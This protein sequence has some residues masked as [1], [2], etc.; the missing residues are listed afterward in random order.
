MGDKGKKAAAATAGFLVGGPV[1][2]AVAYKSTESYQE[3][4]N[5]AKEAGAASALAASESQ[6]AE[7]AETELRKR[8]NAMFQTSGESS[9]A[10]VQPGQ[11][12][13]RDTF[14]GN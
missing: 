8:R 2:A 5:K 12:S 6:R 14:F 7:T 10:V 9:G 11:V 4:G 1:G 3:K 13:A